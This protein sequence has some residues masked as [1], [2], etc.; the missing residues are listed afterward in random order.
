MTSER[1]QERFSFL[2]YGFDVSGCEEAIAAGK[3]PFTELTW[4]RDFITQYAEQ[5]LGLSRDRTDGISGLIVTVKVA[6]ARS[7]GPTATAEPVLLVEH[8]PKVGLLHINGKSFFLVNGNHRMAKA[9]FEDADS[10]KVRQVARKH[11]KAFLL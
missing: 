4:D 3:V 6:H 8:Q 11:A 1:P 5:L 7:L 2:R 10:I 9:Y